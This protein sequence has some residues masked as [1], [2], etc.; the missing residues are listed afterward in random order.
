M[1][2]SEEL[3]AKLFYSLLFILIQVAGVYFARLHYQNYPEDIPSWDQFS[4]VFHGLGYL[5]HRK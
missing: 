2:L 3:K 1:K 4:Q 5:I